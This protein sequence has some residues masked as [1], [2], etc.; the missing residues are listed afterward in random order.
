MADDGKTYLAFIDKRKDYYMVKPDATPGKIDFENIKRI[1][2]P[3]NR[4]FGQVDA[5]KQGKDLAKSVA[6]KLPV[7]TGPKL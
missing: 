3:V 1:Y 5:L 7:P 4:G 6:A 2:D